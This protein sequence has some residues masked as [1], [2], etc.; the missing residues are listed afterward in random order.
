[1]VKGFNVFNTRELVK[2]VISSLPGQRGQFL[3]MKGKARKKQ[4]ENIKKRIEK[5]YYTSESIASAIS[6]KRASSFES[7]ID[8]YA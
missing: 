3:Y 4:V 2:M 1:M 6:E 5:G 8:R 7:E